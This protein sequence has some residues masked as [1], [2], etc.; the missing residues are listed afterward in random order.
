MKG[1]RRVS[2]MSTSPRTDLRSTGLVGVELVEATNDAN[3]IGSCL[4]AMTVDR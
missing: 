1:R 3:S 2:R 4:D